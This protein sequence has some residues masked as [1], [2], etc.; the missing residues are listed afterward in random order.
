MRVHQSGE[1]GE[2]VSVVSTKRDEKRRSI[3][4][5]AERIAELPTAGMTAKEISD[6]LGAPLHLVYDALLALGYTTDAGDFL[7]AV[8]TPEEPRP[9]YER[10]AQIDTSD[11]TLKEIAKRLDVS[12]SRARSTL[13]F[14]GRF[15]RTGGYKVPPRAKRNRSTS[16]KKPPSEEKPTTKE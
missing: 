12:E 9:L 4:H 16:K 11:M 5:L 10:M 6:S 15:A 8:G 13:T 14:L 1:D 3:V 2:R 7:P